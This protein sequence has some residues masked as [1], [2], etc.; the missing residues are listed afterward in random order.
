MIT[1]PHISN[2]LLFE[3]LKIFRKT[4]FHLKWIFLKSDC[5]ILL[6]IIFWMELNGAKDTEMTEKPL[7][8][9]WWIET[10]EK[11]NLYVKALSS[12]SSSGF[13]WALHQQQTNEKEEKKHEFSFRNTSCAHISICFVCNIVYAWWCTCCVWKWQFESIS[14]FA[15]FKHTFSNEEHSGVSVSVF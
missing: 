10:L 13:Q 15:P 1:K 2:W 7:E 5:T 8:R 12:H 9:S 4:H 6:H 3:A 14:E 11:L